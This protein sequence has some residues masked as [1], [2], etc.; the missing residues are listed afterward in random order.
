M[1]K[2]AEHTG[3]GLIVFGATAQI[4]AQL[5]ATID[6]GETLSSDS[7]EESQGATK[8]TDIKKSR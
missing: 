5:D 7:D 8:G 3:A 4:A 1:D 6:R 2:A